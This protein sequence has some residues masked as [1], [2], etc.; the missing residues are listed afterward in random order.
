[1]IAYFKESWDEL[2]SNVSWLTR[3]KASNLMVVVA[4]FSVILA[5]LTW[6]IDMFFNNIIQQ[7][8]KL[9]TS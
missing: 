1:M 9:F 4:V 5:L 2:R 8:F 7:Y 3:D 6:V